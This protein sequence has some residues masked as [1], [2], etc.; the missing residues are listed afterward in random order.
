MTSVGSRC[1]VEGL[2]VRSSRALLM[3]LSFLQSSH[4]RSK[5]ITVLSLSPSPHPHTISLYLW[6]TS[7]LNRLACPAPPSSGCSLKKT[8]G[9]TESELP[10]ASHDAW[11]TTGHNPRM[12]FGRCK[13][14]TQSNKIAL[15][16]MC[17]KARPCQCKW[18]RVDAGSCVSPVT[19]RMMSGTPPVH[20]QRLAGQGLLGG[21]AGR[22]AER[23]RGKVFLWVGRPGKGEG[24][25]IGQLCKQDKKK[26]PWAMR[27]QFR[28]PKPTWTCAC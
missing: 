27:P 3:S 13:L 28:P 5:H 24:A 20:R 10:V 15:L 7:C 19:Q 6:L 14:I 21:E 22:R 2:L 26:H 11:E 12:F 8:K 17:C 9:I 18:H 16:Q 23:G 4:L 1:S 25:W